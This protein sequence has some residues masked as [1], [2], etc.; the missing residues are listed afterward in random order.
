LSD[1][2]RDFGIVDR[3]DEPRDI[4]LRQMVVHGGLEDA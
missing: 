4:D 1:K 2:F 3:S